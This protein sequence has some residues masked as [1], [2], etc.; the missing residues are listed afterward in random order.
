M[1]TT[2]LSEIHKVLQSRQQE[3]ADAWMGALVNLTP[4]ALD[5]SQLRARFE[6]F[7]DRLASL[8]VSEPFTPSP[9]QEVGVALDMLE[10]FQSKDMVKVQEVLADGL[11]KGMSPE[12]VR[13]LLPRIVAVL[14]ELESGFFTGKTNRA[15]RF[16]M[17]AM[18][19]MGH[20]LKTP[21]NAITGFSRVILKGIDGP[22]T[23]FQQQDLTSIYDAGKKL[24][25]MINDMF[26]VAKS[27]AAK[28]NLYER[29]F[30]VSDLLGDLLKTTQPIL[31]KREHAI[32]MW[33]S[34]DLGKMQADASQVRWIVIGLLFHAAR[35]AEK[36][37]VSLAAARER[38]Q[39]SD[40]LL[41]EVTRTNEEKSLTYE[42]Q[43]HQ[44]M[45]EEPDKD[46]DI[47][48]IT[49]LRFCKEM[50]GAITLA[51]GEDGTPKF[52]LRLP[53]RGIATEPA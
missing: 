18:S 8:L 49:A 37:G 42:P 4:I 40:W 22:I 27:D 17:E 2:E 19:K 33:T 29:S 30:D 26:E 45:I 44:P 41:F 15:K 43:G 50:G 6:G 11:V 20:D 23:E 1:N 13:A 24:L 32:D 34:G 53:A 12:Q 9:A 36:G 10:N 39:N 47:G 38:V 28:T 51:R 7:V 31:A 14:S 25:D 16:D 52:L 46:M 3:I 5:V 35:L 21:I 48:L